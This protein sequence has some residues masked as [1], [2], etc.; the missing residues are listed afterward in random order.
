MDEV[1][2][3]LENIKSFPSKTPST[4]MSRA[5]VIGGKTKKDVIQAFVLGM[6]K[7]YFQSGL[8]PAK[9]N[10]RFPELHK[11]LKALMRQRD[12]NFR[13]TSIQ[14]N[15]NLATNYHIDKNNLGLSYCLSLGNFT[16]GDVIQKFENGMTNHIRTKNRLVKYDGKIEH[17][18]EPFKGTRYA[19]IFFTKSPTR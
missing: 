1:L 10:K 15:K 11:K 2:E 3:S 17:K 8:V 16:G 14:L 18:T 6:A 7:P 9:N 19:I 4:D 5:N 12:P 13:Y